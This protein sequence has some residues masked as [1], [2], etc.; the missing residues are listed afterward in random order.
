MPVTEFPHLLHLSATAPSSRLMH[1]KKG[2]VCSKKG[3]SYYISDMY[4]L[5]LKKTSFEHFSRD[6]FL[7]KIHQ[8]SLFFISKHYLII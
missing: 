2:S 5:I 3:S 8:I 7:N 1:N 6:Q 4:S